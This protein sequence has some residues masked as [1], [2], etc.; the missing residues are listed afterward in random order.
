MSDS[1]HL[2]F[3]PANLTDQEQARL[4][5]LATLKAAGIDTYPARVQ[6]THTIAE[7]R[8]AYAEGKADGE[9][10]VTGR[11]KAMRNM[12]KVSFADLEDGTGQIQIV[13]RR[14]YLPENWYNDIWKKAV[15]LGDFLG[16]SGPLFVTKTGELSVEVHKLQFLSKT[17]KPMPDKWHGVRDQE[18][19]YRRRYVDLI[20]NPEVRDLFRTRAAIVRAL[21]EYLDNE[22]F[23]EVE[24]PILQPVY[25][26]AAARPFVTHHNQLH[27]DLYLRISFELYLKRLIVGGFDKVYEIG[28]DFRNEGV[29]FKHNPE[30]TQLE[31]YEAYVDYNDVMRRTEQMVA[32]VAQ[33]VKGSLTI[34][35][36]GQTI[37][38]TP[39]WRRISLRQA[40]L[41]ESDIDYEAF[42]D[43]AALSEEMKRQRIDHDP[44]QPWGKL[45]DKLLS[46]FV[47][48]KL[49]QPTFL[50]DYPRD[51]SPL[52]KGSPDD[53][54]QVERFEGFMAGMELCN[55]FS[56][57]NDPI[58]QLQR[59]IDENYH[60]AHGDDEAHPVDEDYIEALSFGMPPTGGF[61]MGIDRLTMLLTGKDTIREVILFPHLRTVKEEA[62]EEDEVET[63]LP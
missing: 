61:G 43:A 17:L 59:F 32:Y 51:V 50:V 63:P 36:Q 24:T 41:D 6:R 7:V 57:I 20:A 9:V 21:R 54:R 16:A 12:G 28:R 48:P 37:D 10:T 2:L 26:G 60:A 40:I 1:Q 33:K 52:A 14:D 18:K 25:G 35:W 8:A 29:S 46:T 11:L 55:A 62:A 15:D 56:E 4:Q 45:V 38:L 47:E 3:D 53:P 5:N 58:D 44:S 49:I 22:G 30:F 34:E 31:F 19:R 23:L 42:P 13:V 27:Q 39:P